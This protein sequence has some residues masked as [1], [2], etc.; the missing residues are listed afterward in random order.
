M[1][2]DLDNKW[3]NTF[4]FREAGNTFVKYGYYTSEPWG[5]P[6]WF[7]YWTKERVK[8]LEGFTVDN[9]HIPGEYYFYLNYCLVL[10]IMLN[11]QYYV[12]FP[13]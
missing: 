9:V 6:A 12:V 7:E 3:I 13:F 10:S 5:S 2:R 11:Y 4:S 1:I 8:C